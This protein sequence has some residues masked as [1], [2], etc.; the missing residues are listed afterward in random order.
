MIG[1]KTSPYFV[2][3]GVV[4]DRR[5]TQ[6]TFNNQK[7]LRV[8]ESERQYIILYFCLVYSSSGIIYIFDFILHAHWF[9]SNV[10]QPHDGAHTHMICCLGRRSFGIHLSYSLI[11]ISFWVIC[12]PH[13]TH[14]LLAFQT[15]CLPK[16]Y[17]EQRFAIRDCMGFIVIRFRYR[18]DKK[19][20]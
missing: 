10:Y 5:M 7:N 14:P 18:C 1:Q 2:G 19:I 4:V 9:S 12:F 13:A 16:T 11:Y 6:H 15:Q 17:I 20:Q 8:Y 3:D